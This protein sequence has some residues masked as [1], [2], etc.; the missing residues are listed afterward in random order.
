[1]LLK[2]CLH[3]TFR[4]DCEIRDDIRKR[5]KGL[6]FTVA[7]FKC[8]KRDT[9]WRI[10]QRVV[11]T[12]NVLRNEGHSPWEHYSDQDHIGTIIRRKDGKLVVWLD[13]P[14]DD[15][16]KRQIVKLWPDR[17]D[18][19]AADEPDAVLCPNCKKPEGQTNRSEWHCDTCSVV[20]SQLQ[21]NGVV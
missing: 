5:S 7:S 21:R 10:G 3:C 16:G 2:P 12:F 19:K 13:E 6:P 20:P 8:A 4:D 15:A 9:S 1:M 18:L 17:L 14:L 11:A